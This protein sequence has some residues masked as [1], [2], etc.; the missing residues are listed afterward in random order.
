MNILYEMKYSDPS[1]AH[2]AILTKALVEDKYTYCKKLFCDNFI[3]VVFGWREYNSGFKAADLPP[4]T[5]VF[6][7]QELV[8][9]YGPSLSNFIDIQLVEEP[10]LI[11]N[12]KFKRF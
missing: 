7:K 6:D 8:K 10:Q 4:N 2:P 3:F 1:S 11:A 12:S 5:V 9:L